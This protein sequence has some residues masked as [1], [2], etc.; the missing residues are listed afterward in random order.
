M[1]DIKKLVRQAGI[2]SVGYDN[3]VKDKG[4]IWAEININ[5]IT[6]V[7]ERLNITVY[8]VKLYARKEKRVSHENAIKNIIAM[9]NDMPTFSFTSSDNEDDDT[10][11]IQQIIIAQSGRV[12]KE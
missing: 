1:R 5:S 9:A 12:N 7:T 2:S 10:L 11:L 3:E 4:G 8:R 6:P